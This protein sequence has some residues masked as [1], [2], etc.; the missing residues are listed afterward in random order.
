MGD[1]EGQ[2]VLQVILALGGLHIDHDGHGD[3]HFLGEDLVLHT[4]REA[5]AHFAGFLL[6]ALGGQRADVLGDQR[7]HRLLV[8]GT[9]EDEGEV[10]GI[11]EALLGDL[12][13]AGV[14][15]V[16]HVGGL[17]LGRTRI[18]VVEGAGQGILQG[19]HR[20]LLGVEQLGAR[21]VLPRLEGVRIGA[22]GREVQ[23]GQLEHR[24]E[25]L[26]RRIA[27]HAFLVEV[28]VRVDAHLLAGERLGQGRGAEVA[29]AAFGEQADVLQGKGFAFRIE[30][31]TALAV[32][33][34]D[35]LVLVEVGGFHID[36]GAVGELVHR[37]AELVGLAL[38]DL[39]ARRNLGE[40]RFVGD[41]F[42]IGFNLF[43]RHVGE[44]LLHF[45]HRGIGH[46]FLLGKH[47]GQHDVLAFFHERAEQLVDHFDRNVR[48]E[49]LAEGKFFLLAHDRLVVDEVADI[50][51]AVGSAALLLA[52]IVSR[53]Y[54]AHVFSPGA[55][56][57]TCGETAAFCTEDF[58]PDRCNCVLQLV[59][60]TNDDTHVGFLRLGK[61]IVLVRA[62]LGHHERRLGQ[63]G[64]FFKTLV[65]HHGSH[66]GGILIN[67]IIHV[68][69]HL[70]GICIVLPEE[71][72]LCIGELLVCRHA[73]NGFVVVLYLH[74]IALCRINRGG[75]GAEYLL[76]LALYLVDV[77]VAD[78]NDTLVVRTVP[79][80]IVVA[81]HFIREVV[82]DFHKADRQALAILVVIGIDL[83]QD[84]LI[85]THLRVLAA[86]PLLMDHTTLTVDI[87]VGKQQA[88]RPVVKD[89][90]AGVD[91]ARNLGHGHVV[92]IIDRFVDAGIGVQVGA[93]LH[94]DRLAVFHN[95]VAGEMLGSVEAHMLEEMGETAL[96]FVFQNGAHFL[97]DIEIGLAL[98]LF[99]VPDVIG[100][101]VV[102]FTDF[103]VRIHRDRRHLLGGCHHAEA[104]CQ[105]SDN[106][107]DSFHLNDC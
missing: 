11:G 93:E 10:G 98:R 104:E 52:G 70:H 12:H 77:D 29:H 46:A 24:L 89:P 84:L 1:V 97:G 50:F 55:L 39:A 36:R 20:L 16:V 86:A 59:F 95:A 3:F 76:D 74:I 72:G 105:G 65:E 27:A 35:D 19:G 21:L 90:E 94:A 37:I 8:D 91:G 28:D 99:V 5:H 92:D 58:A 106:S 38:D 7:Q 48:A 101:S 73:H 96:R 44:H 85:E 45:V 25:I 57:F 67:Q 107:N 63:L 60:A 13:H 33:A 9:R 83:R 56:I 43:G 102:E 34:Q 71:E 80:L 42:L 82:H 30:R 2:V 78:H 18:V 64:E 51:R 75:D 31:G 40:Q 87:L 15:H 23:V 88:V 49:L 61:E 103:H 79:F 26:R 81:Q 4:L 66:Y 14:V 17:H 53:F 32:G 62:E 69:P 47:A 68:A 54:L 100:Q 6:L 41:F 22:L